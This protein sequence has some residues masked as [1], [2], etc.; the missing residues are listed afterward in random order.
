MKELD[1][2]R[3]KKD[4]PEMELKRGQRGTIVLEPKDDKAE[5]EFV[6]KKGRTTH[7]EIFPLNALEL[8][9]AAK[10]PIKL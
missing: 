7:L 10:T 8:V 9:C 5:V 2:V 6:D 1:I 4:F 3:L